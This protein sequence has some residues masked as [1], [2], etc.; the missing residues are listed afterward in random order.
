M[1]VDTDVRRGRARADPPPRREH[2]INGESVAPVEGEYF[3]SINPTT[4]RRLLRGGP[5]D[6]PPTW[7]RP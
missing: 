1:T 4:G 6:A 7:T 3:E 2:F 5:R